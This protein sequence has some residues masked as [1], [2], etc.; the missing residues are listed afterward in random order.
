MR[1]GSA[2]LR[3]PAETGAIGKY[4]TA[5][6]DLGPLLRGLEE[7]DDRSQQFQTMLTTLDALSYA[8]TICGALSH[9]P[10]RKSHTLRD[11]RT[12]W[13]HRLNAAALDLACA[14]GQNRSSADL[15]RQAWTEV[16]PLREAPHDSSN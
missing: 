16:Q 4:A 14:A 8:D 11:I 5:L 15:V 6:A 2:R 12:K 7:S 10:L 9:P 13:S 1:I 3:N